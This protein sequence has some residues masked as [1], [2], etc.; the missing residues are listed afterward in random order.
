MVIMD[1]ELLGRLET[2]TARI[3]KLIS[4]E[5]GK[6]DR[7]YKMANNAIVTLEERHNALEQRV[8]TLE[9]QL[10]EALEVITYERIE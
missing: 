1:A 4:V 2:L 6:K 5:Q 10:A 8:F 9:R 7:A 3:E